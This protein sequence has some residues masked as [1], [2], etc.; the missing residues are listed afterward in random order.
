MQQYHSKN[1]KGFTI[2][3]LIAILVIIGVVGAV[4]AGRFVNNPAESIGAKDVIK[5]HIR[6][7][8]V[9]AM[10]S[11]TVCGIVFNQTTYSLFRNGSTLDRITLPGNE[12]TSFAIPG[13]LGTANETIYFDLWGAPHTVLAVSSP[14]PT[15]AIGTLGLTMII[16]TGHVQ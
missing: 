10:K 8:Q 16:D 2:I 11:N 14:R 15:G 3:E 13:G 5:S 7:A 6:Y 12:T 1:V 9:M 4:A